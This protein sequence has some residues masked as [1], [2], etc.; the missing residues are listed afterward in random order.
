[1][2]TVAV[3][4]TRCVFNPLCVQPAVCSIMYDLKWSHVQLLCVHLYVLLR[5]SVCSIPYDLMRSYVRRCVFIYTILRDLVFSLCPGK[6]LLS[7]VDIDWLILFGCAIL[8]Y[9]AN[10]YGML[11]CLWCV[12]VILCVLTNVFGISCVMYAR[13]T[14][15]DL[16][17]LTCIV[18]SVCNDTK[19]FL[20]VLSKPT[21]SP[22]LCWLFLVHFSGIAGRFDAR[23]C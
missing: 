15:S 5:T 18:R 23:D 21:S 17:S 3:C 10:V 13:L 8:L 6:D 20:N 9:C 7:Y 2:C 4:S 1:M 16:Y 12:N 14:V 22:A 19:L 11:L